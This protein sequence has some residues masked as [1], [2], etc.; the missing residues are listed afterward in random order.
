MDNYIGVALAVAT[1]VAV[2]L[3]SGFGNGDKMMKAPGQP[4]VKI[5]RNVFE[6]DPSSYF[7]NLR[8]N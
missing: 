7:R 2:L 5:P 3:F 8:K 6:N 4:G 1:A